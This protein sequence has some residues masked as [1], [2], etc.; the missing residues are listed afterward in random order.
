VYPD[1]KL[2]H[3]I[4]LSTAIVFAIGVLLSIYFNSL[5][6]FLFIPLGLGWTFSR[7]SEAKSESDQESSEENPQS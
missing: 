6:I 7:K 2:S 1:L 4:L 3:L 5:F